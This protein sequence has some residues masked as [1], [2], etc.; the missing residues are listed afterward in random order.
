M[1]VKIKGFVAMIIDSL[2]TIGGVKRGMERIQI[3]NSISHLV[4]GC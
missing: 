1:K 3:M 4:F 2:M